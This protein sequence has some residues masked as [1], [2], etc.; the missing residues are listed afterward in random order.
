MRHLW[1]RK[2]LISRGTLAIGTLPLGIIRCQMR[3]TTAITLPYRSRPHDGPFNPYPIRNQ[4]N[5]L[6]LI[7][8]LRSRE[9]CRTVVHTNIPRSSWIQV[10]LL[11]SMISHGPRTGLNAELVWS[12][13]TGHPR[14]HRFRCSPVLGAAQQDD[15]KTN[16]N[17]HV[18]GDNNDEPGGRQT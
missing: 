17:R 2:V 5:C 13:R 18:C 8:D 7:L 4:C 10:T 1:R 6:A 12:P 11:C 3:A 14:F 16:E 15:H 9:G